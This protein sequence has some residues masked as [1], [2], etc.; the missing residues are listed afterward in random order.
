MGFKPYSYLIF[1]LSDTS[2]DRSAFAERLKLKFSAPN[3]RIEA[4]DQVTIMTI[5]S[6]SFRIYYNQDPSVVEE[7]AEIAQ[8]YAVDHVDQE[9]IAA[10]SRRLETSGDADPD[11]DYFN[12]VMIFLEWVEK[13]YQVAVY[14]G[15]EGFL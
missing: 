15:Q 5:D 11:M 3:I 8:E 10:C 7:S 2:W 13:E 12:D 6:W 14:D 1:L 9:R 4:T